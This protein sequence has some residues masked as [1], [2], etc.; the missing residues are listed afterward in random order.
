M[1]PQ[2]RAR[3]APGFLGRWGRGAGGRTVALVEALKMGDEERRERW[4]VYGVWRDART[5]ADVEEQ[6]GLVDRHAGRNPGM[7]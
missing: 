7:G 1:R 4:G 5:L 6:E 3:G 2:N